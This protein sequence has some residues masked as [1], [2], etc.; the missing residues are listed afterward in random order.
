[1]RRARGTPTLLSTPPREN[2][3]PM[4]ES[5]QWGLRSTRLESARAPFKGCSSQNGAHALSATDWA[6]EVRS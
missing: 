1:M 3:L 4:S 2:Q 6:L 5:T